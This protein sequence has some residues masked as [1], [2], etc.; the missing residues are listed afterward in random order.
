MKKTLRNFFLLP[1]VLLL[2]ST[3]TFAQDKESNNHVTLGYR[4]PIFGDNSNVARFQR[5]ND[6]SKGW[7]FD[8][9][10]LHSKTPDLSW[11][12]DGN[13][14][15]YRNQQVNGALN[16]FGKLKLS[17][18]YNQIPIFYNAETR[19]LYSTDAGV[20]TLDDSIQGGV[21]GGTLKLKDAVKNTNLFDLRSS[22]N[23]FDVNTKYSFSNH[24][25]A[26][27]N[28][29]NTHVTGNQQWSMNFNGFSMADEFPLPKDHT[30]TDVGTGIEVTSKHSWVRLGY[31]HSAFT[32]NIPVL[33]ID[34]P[35]RL[36]N[37]P[38]AGTA[39]SMISPWPNTNQGTASISSWFK[40]PANT[41]VT[42]YFSAS[43][44]TNNSQLLPFT[45]N[46]AL[47]VFPLAR[48]MSEI[49][50]DV[51][52]GN[53]KFSSHPAKWLTF[54]S[55]YRTY[56]FDNLTEPFFYGSVIN[57]DTAVVAR[58]KETEPLSFKRETWDSDVNVN[59]FRYLGFGVGYTRA[60][61]EQTHRATE[62]SVEG[63]GRFTVDFT[64]LSWVMVRGAYDHSNREGNFDG[65]E[66]FL[67]GGQQP[68]LRQYD[69]SDRIK[70][71]YSLMLVVTPV[72]WLS[73]NGTRSAGKED[74]PATDTRTIFGLRNNHSNSYTMGFD[75]TPADKISFDASYGFDKFN[76]FQVSRTANPVTG[77]TDEQKL[78][79]L[80]D[81]SQQYNDPR[82]NWNLS[83]N[84]WSQT[85][86]SS[87][88][89][90]KL[91]PKTDI[92]LN[93]GDMRSKSTYVF[94]VPVDS[95]IPAPVQLPPITNRLNQKSIRSTYHYNKNVAFMF[96]YRFDDLTVDD[97]AFNPRASLAEPVS[98]A[99]QNYL[100]MGNFLKGYKAQ[101]ATIGVTYRW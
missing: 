35:L 95:I 61:R 59:P 90:T 33:S 10:Q 32:N 12:F 85:F 71:R 96:M 97:F 88:S 99:Q 50:A 44:L 38:T 75:L 91:I 83:N 42:G 67:G 3:Q 86:D 7:T 18:G 2:F 60:K 16:V 19:T 24:F 100:M 70:D 56:N 25:A 31:D 41:T 43:N 23:I 5:Y 55:K 22:R 8:D 84:D 73:L 82:R 63:T 28:F 87:L 101:V 14:I 21:Q 15:G 98:A 79:S 30:T 89:F 68:S 65:M 48:E 11:K 13:H 72:S 93:Y 80:V 53:F 47:P 49:K 40:L 94:G 39:F 36:T 1:V 52:A 62:E 78:A 57:Y 76:T 69:I 74:Y 54:G 34:N 29:K 26:T 46:S 51:F 66:L 58:N 27:L 64:G 17:V 9:F 45:S 20:L 77:T 92:S 81:P 37:S 4:L 6:L